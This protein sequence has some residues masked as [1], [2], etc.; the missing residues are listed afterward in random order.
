MVRL[1][2]RVKARIATM[3]FG[4][5]IGSLA[6]LVTAVAV[7]YRYEGTTRDTGPC[8]AIPG[9]SSWPTGDTWAALNATLGGKLIASMPIA[10]PC[11]TTLFGQANA[12]F[13][14]D[15]CATLRDHWFFPET[16]LASSSSPMAYA[17]SNNSCNPFLAPAA[18]CTIGSLAVYTI[19]ATGTADFQHAVRFAKRHNVRLVIRNTGH[20]YLGK[21]TGAHSLTVWARHMKAMSVINYHDKTYTGLALKVGAGVEVI[22]AYRYASSQGLVVVGGN[23]PTVALAGGFT[24][25]GGHGPLASRY[26][27]SADQVLEWELVTGIGEVVTVSATRNSDLFWA[28]RGGGGGTFGIVSSLTVKAF[29]DTRT[30]VASVTLLNNGTN[31]D[32]VYSAVASF[33]RD[34]LP[35]LVDAGAFVVWI[36]APFGFMI[37][38]AIA[39]GLSSAE[40]DDLMRP[41]TLGLEKLGLEFQYS[42]AQYPT[43]LSSYEAL[44]ETA[45]WNV[46]DYN[47][48]SRLIP[49]EL[50]TQRTENLV[51]ALRYIAS[52]T[53]MSGVSYNLARGNISAE[54]V[55]VNPYIRSSL[56]SVTVGT[57][58][59]YTDWPLTKIAQDKLTHDLLPSLEKLTP[60]GAVYLNEADFQ[61]PDFQQ[62]IY[63]DN[64]GKL[65]DIKKKYDPH[66]VFYART[67]VGSDEWAENSNGR[68]CK[69]RG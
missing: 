62:A 56:F 10:A 1:Y 35:S 27:L 44:Q 48:G 37:A 59:D 9:D 34:T 21:S 67:A 30:S 33:I 68:L 65:R 11:H 51:E 26:G 58:I 20:D 38:P 5:S 54:T 57:P 69:V 18:P 6:V 31:T 8:R 19:N 7:A 52:Q 41:M 66:D 28:L 2:H 25:G 60:G 42:S 45:T 22:E 64:Y 47:V 17:F 13:N 39:P 46:S 61:Q 29:P 3:P 55:A 50:A 15:E 36:A 53:L 23:C 14:P 24:Q 12:V 49:R 63:G 16:H 32:S 40:L 4:L 43:F